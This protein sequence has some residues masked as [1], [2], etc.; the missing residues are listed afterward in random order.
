MELKGL[1][2]CRNQLEKLEIPIKSLT[3]DRHLQIQAYMKTKW[4]NVQ[5]FFDTW[6][7]GKGK[8]FVT[9]IVS[10]FSLLYL[11][12]FCD[13]NIQVVIFTISCTMF[14]AWKKKLAA[15]SLKSK[16]RILAKW[17]KS[18]CNHMYWVVDTTEHQTKFRES[19]WLSIIDHIANEHTFGYPEFSSCEHG[20]LGNLVDDNG[21]HIQ[22]VWINNWVVKYYLSYSV[23][24]NFENCS[25]TTEIF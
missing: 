12:I 11:A 10:Q 5:H 19:K 15:L 4:P 20:L 18:I 6:H 23:I 1:I 3:T 25:G 17:I 7:I 14:Q 21:K 2:S 24:S 9:Q 8:L 13:I 16:H 22:R